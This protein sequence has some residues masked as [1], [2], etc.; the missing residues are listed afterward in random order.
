MNVAE[1]EQMGNSGQ[2]HKCILLVKSVIPEAEITSWLYGISP[3]P[4]DTSSPFSPP[5]LYIIVPVI[6][7]FL[8][9]KI[10]N[11]FSPVMKIQSFSHQD[12]T[13]KVSYS[14]HQA[15]TTSAYRH[16]LFA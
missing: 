1:P 2:Q 12:P 13:L 3:K 7:D 5:T 11:K 6:T 10:T 4:P 14:E 15:Q 9:S 8:K 16:V